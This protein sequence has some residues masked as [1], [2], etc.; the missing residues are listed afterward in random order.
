ME[1]KWWFIGAGVIG[2]VL[3][4]LVFNTLPGTGDPTAPIKGK[5]AF[6]EAEASL[7]AEEAPVARMPDRGGVTAR[8]RPDALKRNIAKVPPGGLAVREDGVRSG[9]NPVSQALVAS[10]STPEGLYAGRAQA[11]F[12]LIRRQLMLTG[13]ADAK[14]MA[15]QIG[16]LIADLRDMRRNPNP[17]GWD[18]LEGQMESW[19]NRIANSDYAEEEHVGQSIE[20][21]EGILE[22]FHVAKEEQEN[23]ADDV[24]EESP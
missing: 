16:N 21:L 12:A 4:L 9:G 13:E 2:I 20:R 22:E 18:A 15:N 23:G 14:A 24:D 17:D 7:G 11:P 8:L 6:D 10:R 5:V 3:A 1:K 19:S